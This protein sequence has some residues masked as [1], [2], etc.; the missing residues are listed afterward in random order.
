MLPYG[1]SPYKMA[2]VSRQPAIY[3]PVLFTILKMKFLS[4]LVLASMAVAAPSKRAPTP[5]DVKLEM[6]SNSEVKATV[7]NNGKNNLKLFKSGTFLDSAP[8]EKVTVLSG[9]T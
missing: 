7:T 1:P 8:V 2:N 5:L 9:G 4:T 6:V 3:C